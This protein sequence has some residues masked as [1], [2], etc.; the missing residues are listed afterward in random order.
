V[1]A[2][3]DEHAVENPTA[4]GA[5]ENKA[6]DGHEEYEI[7]RGAL[8]CINRTLWDFSLGR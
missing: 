2:T 6:K 8:L 3:P 4:I 1:T 5:E 7:V